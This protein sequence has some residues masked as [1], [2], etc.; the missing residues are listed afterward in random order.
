[1][2]KK[3]KKSQKIKMINKKKNQRMKIKNLKK[4]INLK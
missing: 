1:M 3:L 2:K 4:K